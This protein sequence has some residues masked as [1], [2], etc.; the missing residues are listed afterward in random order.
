MRLASWALVMVM[1]VGC[2][3]DET[4]P[5]EQVP[6]GDY[7]YPRIQVC[8]RNQVCECQGR[9]QPGQAPEDAAGPA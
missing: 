1:A 2:E 7:C 4:P 8:D 9:A 6:P 3:F 5:P